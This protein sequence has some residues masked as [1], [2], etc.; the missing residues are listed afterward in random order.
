MPPNHI[1]QAHQPVRVDGMEVENRNDHKPSDVRYE[2]RAG[3]NRPCE[4]VSI[5]KTEFGGDAINFIADGTHTE[6]ER[7]L[8]A[9]R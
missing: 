8:N 4:L 5:V 1:L 7:I 6:C 2:I 3:R 9:L